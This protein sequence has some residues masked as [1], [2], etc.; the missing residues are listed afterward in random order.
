[1]R[2]FVM[3]TGRRLQL[4][5]I[6]VAAWSNELEQTGLWRYL[7]PQIARAGVDVLAN[8]LQLRMLGTLHDQRADRTDCE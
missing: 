8:L 2:P 6:V 4:P 5:A 1:M 3:G 7:G